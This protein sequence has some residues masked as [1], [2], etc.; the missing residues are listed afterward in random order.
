MRC[1]FQRTKPNY[2]RRKIIEQANSIPE[3]NPWELVVDDDDDGSEV[4][5][6][7]TDHNIEEAEMTSDEFLILCPM[8]LGF[9][10]VDKQ[11]DKLASSLKRSDC[12]IYGSQLNLP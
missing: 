9:S 12:R 3:S 8:L 1:S 5:H 2:S 6:I 11:W 7:A 4:S 10:S